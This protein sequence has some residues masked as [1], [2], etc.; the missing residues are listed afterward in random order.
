MSSINIL[1]YCQPC[2]PPAYTTS[3][4]YLRR[5]RKTLEKRCWTLSYKYIDVT[6]FVDKS[7][8]RTNKSHESQQIPMNTIQLHLNPMFNPRCYIHLRWHFY[9]SSSQ[10]VVND[11]V[12]SLCQAHLLCDFFILPICYLS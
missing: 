3:R 10:I 7:S 11:L 9:S 12:K 6:P 8:T 1:I 2:S 4:F 5:R